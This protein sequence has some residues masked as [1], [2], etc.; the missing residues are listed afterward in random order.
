MRSVMPRSTPIYGLDTSVFVRLLTGHPEAEYKSSV[1]A[2]K[3]LHEKEPS[4]E[5]VVSNQVIGE[6][7]ITLQHFYKIPKKEARRAISE[8]FAS[9]NVSP[10]NGAKV[11]EILKASSGAGLMDRLIIQDYNQRGLSVLTND[12][13]MA[14]VEGARIL[15]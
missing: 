7:Y 5:L 10:L 12:K 13:Q 4:T 2:L 8:L 9:G 11:L 3:R 15:K 1:I 14:K 6:A